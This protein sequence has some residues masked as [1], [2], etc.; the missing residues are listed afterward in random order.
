MISH[1]KAIDI[2]SQLSSRNSKLVYPPQNLIDLVWKAKPVR[3]REP[4]FIHPMEFTGRSALDK[5]EDIRK[6]I[7]DTPPATLSYSKSPPS[8][9]Q[10]HVAT[11]ISALDA[12][13]RIN[14]PVQLGSA[15]ILP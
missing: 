4:I 7:R 3:S 14:L 15:L 9:A 12:I 11:L 5:L 6:C 13:G 2:N 10:F 1:I 8:P